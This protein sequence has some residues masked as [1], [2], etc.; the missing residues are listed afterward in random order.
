[1]TYAGNAPI[2]LG[3]VDIDPTEMMFWMYLPISRPGMTG[4][5][6]PPNLAQFKPL[7]DAVQKDLKTNDQWRH[8]HDNKWTNSY[9]YLTA[10]T[11][12]VEGTYI[13]NRPGWHIDGYGTYDINYIWADRAPTDFLILNETINLSNDCDESLAEMERLAKNAHPGLFRTY[14]D[15]HLLRLDN[16]VIHRSPVNFPSGMRTFIKI[17]VSHEKYNLKGN[18]VNHLLPETHWQLVDRQLARNHPVYKNSDYVI[19]EEPA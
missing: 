5:A 13:G 6:L 14:P 10:K 8:E 12:W 7:I 1:M 4:M 17:S 11:L 15:K 3:L 16:T 2:D 9:I 19:L 18:A